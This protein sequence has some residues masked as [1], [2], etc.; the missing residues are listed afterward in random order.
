M[1][2]RIKECQNPCQAMLRFHRNVYFTDNCFLFTSTLADALR[3]MD[4]SHVL[5]TR[6]SRTPVSC[7]TGSCTRTFPSLF[8]VFSYLYKYG[9]STHLRLLVLSPFPFYVCR[10]VHLCFSLMSFSLCLVDLS[11]CLP[12]LLTLSCFSSSTR[13]PS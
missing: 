10:L 9:L 5:R 1:F 7:A 12:L 6:L 8:H 2:P 3:S 11:L 13:L 4:V